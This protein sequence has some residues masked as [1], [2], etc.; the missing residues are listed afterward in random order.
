MEPK[1][2]WFPWCTSAYK[3]SFVAKKVEE[4]RNSNE[5]WGVRVRNKYYIDVQLARNP[6]GVG[7]LDK[8]EWNELSEVNSG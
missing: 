3:P 1:L 2:V 5:Y 6:S 4:L 7:L 8:S